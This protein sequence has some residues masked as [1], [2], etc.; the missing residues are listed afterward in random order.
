MGFFDVLKTIGK[1]AA[2][3]IPGGNLAVSVLEGLGMAAEA[4]GGEKGRKIEQGLSS[5][6][7]GLRDLASEPMSPEQQ[8]R[9]VEIK[10]SH[11]HT[12]AEINLREKTL[13]Y[14]DQA[15][16]RGVIKTALLSDD[17]IVRQARPKM[18]IL[19]G[20]TCIVFV[21]FAP[22]LVFIGTLAKLADL[23]SLTLILK[24]AGGFLFGS[25]M[26]SF[27]GY[28]VARTVDKKISALEPT[29]HFLEMA[30]SL[31]RKFS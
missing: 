29:G 25:F 12:M 16:G 27:T 15:G 17:P 19:I 28:T 7:E 14:K 31:G 4:V 8:V 1:G 30:A 2:S 21:F 23:A 18:M 6:A 20:K 5:V 11:E 26:T 3:L 24:W 13:V 22:I 10:A 9:L